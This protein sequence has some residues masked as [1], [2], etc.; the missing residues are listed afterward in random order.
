MVSSLGEGG[1]EKF[2]VELAIEQKDLG[3]DVDIFVMY[4]ALDINKN[5]DYELGLL[6]NLNRKEIKVIFLDVNFKR[7]PYA[8]VKSLEDSL[9]NCSYDIVHSHF[10][11][12]SFLFRFLPKNKKNVTQIFTQHINELKKP[13]L[14]KWFISRDVAKYIAIC[15]Q[16]AKNMSIYLDDKKIVKIVNG[17]DRR[18][19]P[20]YERKL[21]KL[22]RIVTIS[23]V[24]DQKNPILIF[25]ALVEVKKKGGDFVWNVVGDGPKINELKALVA[26]STIS[27]SVIF[28]GVKNNV[29]DYLKNNDIYLLPSKD[30]GFS[31]GLIEALASGINIIASTV[32]G[33]SET[34]NYGTLGMLVAPNSLEE[35]VDAIIISLNSDNKMS[36]SQSDVLYK[37]EEL[38][39]ERCA[40][41]HIN[42]YNQC[43]IE[44]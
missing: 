32:G 17:I 27:N 2:V 11:W 43:L 42:T 20:F 38:S 40:V 15:N 24:T 34:L 31:I 5:N 3:H 19:F 8:A 37:L 10:I 7:R 26:N 21:K 39:I 23:R 29:S 14:H 4:R 18:K 12:S 35:L 13:Y 6:R 16:A 36:N 41:E 1:A 28:H 9:E 25:L 33:N 30:E 22:T 44:G